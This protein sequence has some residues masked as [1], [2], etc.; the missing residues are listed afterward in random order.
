MW[1]IAGSCTRERQRAPC[2]PLLPL[3]RVLHVRNIVP[4]PVPP[5]DTTDDMNTGKAKPKY[6]RKA[7]AVTK[8]LE[9]EEPAHQVRGIAARAG[10]G[11]SCT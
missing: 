3:R 1:V 10:F 4:P 9:D 8:P 7:L 5:E 6:K 11:A 2:G